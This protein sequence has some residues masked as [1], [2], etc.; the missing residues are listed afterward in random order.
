MKKYAPRKYMK[1]FEPSVIIGGCLHYAPYNL[2]YY[3]PGFYVAFVLCITFE[4][5]MKLGGR[6]ITIFY[7]LD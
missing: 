5:D 1:Y 3:I 2:S 6:S 7:Q 4:R